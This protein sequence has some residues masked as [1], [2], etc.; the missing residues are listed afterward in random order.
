MIKEGSVLYW[1]KSTIQC[2]NRI[3]ERGV[4]SPKSSARE[5]GNGIEASSLEEDG[6]ATR[7]EQSSGA[8][9]RRTKG[10]ICGLS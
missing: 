4:E 7:D 2:L 5:R 8:R 6:S 1:F 3:R 9:G 10:R